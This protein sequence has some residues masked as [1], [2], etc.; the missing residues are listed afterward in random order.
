ME[1]SRI[2]RVRAM[3]QAMGEAAAAVEE[4]RA[5]LEKYRE[6]Q[7]R[8]K[9]LERYYGSALWTADHDADSAGELPADLPRGV[10]SEDALYDLLCDNDH[11]RQELHLPDGENSAEPA[12]TEARGAVVEIRAVRRGAYPDLSAQYENP[13]EH[14]CDVE[15]GRVWFSVNGEKPSD[16]CDSAWETLAP[17]VRRLACGGGNFY[18]GWMKDP[19]SAMLSCNDGFRPVSFY[20]RAVDE[21]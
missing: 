20:I 19:R 5:A 3:E 4:L 13:I 16:F 8:L 2:D 7:P 21:A 12:R 9:A 17:F 1:Q 6:I 18:D 11:L 10:L 15:E 14:A